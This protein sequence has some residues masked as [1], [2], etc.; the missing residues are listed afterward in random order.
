[1]AAPGARSTGVV[2]L[3][4]MP[5]DRWISM[6]TRFKVALVVFTTAP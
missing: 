3:S 5:F 2:G 6:R 1:M 4:S